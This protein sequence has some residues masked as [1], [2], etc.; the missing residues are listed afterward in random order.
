[1]LLRVWGREGGSGGWVAGLILRAMM[2]SQ[3]A[4][5]RTTKCFTKRFM[6]D[7]SNALSIVTAI[8]EAAGFFHTKAA[9]WSTLRGWIAEAPQFVLLCH[10][11]RPGWP[12]LPAH[13]KQKRTASRPPPPPTDTSTFHSLLQRLSC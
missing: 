1:M 4:A 8:A 7:S 12:G 5:A 6:R 2:A 3:P 9:G 11:Q 10:T 13:V